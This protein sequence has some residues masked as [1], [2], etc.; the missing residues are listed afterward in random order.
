MHE[1]RRDMQIHQIDVWP[2]KHEHN[3]IKII[4]IYKERMSISS[5]VSSLL[6]KQESE[7]KGPGE[8]H[9][10]LFSLVELPL[11]VEMNVCLS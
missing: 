4:G 8:S 1:I 7:C 5:R 6:N 9:S 3:Q 11:F 10:I 2:I